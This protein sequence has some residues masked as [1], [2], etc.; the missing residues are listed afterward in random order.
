M[1]T[2]P[3]SRPGARMARCSDTLHDE[4]AKPWLV[5]PRGEVWHGSGRR[6]EDRRRKSEDFVILS[7]AK[8]PPANPSVLISGPSGS[9]ASLRMTEQEVLRLFA[10][11]ESGLRAAEFPELGR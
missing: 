6:T 10:A 9:F 7:E 2:E 8:D 3:P 5:E 11:N 4:I 1:A